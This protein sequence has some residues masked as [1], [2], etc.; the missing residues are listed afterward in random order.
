MYVQGKSEYSFIILR[1][2]IY[3]IYDA[4]AQ[5]IYLVSWTILHIREQAY[6][7]T[8]SILIFNCLFSSFRIMVS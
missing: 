3:K 7:M 6:D 2:D 8:C 5:G 1:L 4:I